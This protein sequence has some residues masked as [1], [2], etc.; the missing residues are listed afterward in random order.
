[1]AECL[2]YHLDHQFGY[3]LYALANEYFARLNDTSTEADVMEIYSSLYRDKS[4]WTSSKAMCGSLSIL[5]REA[6]RSAKVNS[7][8]FGTSAFW[9]IVRRRDKVKQAASLALARA[10]GFYHYYGDVTVSPD[11]AHQ[12]SVR[13][14]EDALRAVELSD[15]YLDVFRQ[16]LQDGQYIEIFYED[17]LESEAKFI[18]Q[19]RE[20]MGLERLADFS[21]YES[22]AKLKSTAHK[23]KADCV[24]GFKFWLLENYHAKTSR[25][26]LTHRTV[27]SVARKMVDDLDLAISVAERHFKI[28]PNALHKLIL[29][30]NGRRRSGVM[31]RRHVN[32]IRSIFKV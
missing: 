31:T 9:I 2:A 14:L 28:K 1:V 32:L 4:G 27:N 7:A 3:S 26:K 21:S 22:L 18:S 20:F 13:Q 25:R 17:F 29:E 19:I 8:F 23:T 11:Q 5:V 15:T 16:H 6:R 24:Q 10:A 30:S 12:I